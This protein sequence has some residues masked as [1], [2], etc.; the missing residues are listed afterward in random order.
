MVVPPEDECENDAVFKYVWILYTGAD[1]GG[2]GADTTEDYYS[3]G[4]NLQYLHRCFGTIQPE[5]PETGSVSLFSHSEVFSVIGARYQLLPYIYSEYMK[6]ALRNTMMFN[7]LS[8]IYGKDNLARQVEDQL[9]VGENIMIAPVCEQNVTGRVVYF[10]ER[11]KQ[12]IFKDGIIEEGNIF[13]KG[14]SYVNMPMGTVNVFLREG[15]LLPVA[16]GGK[17]VE[18]INFED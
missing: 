4:Q 2:F 14:F 5:E 8:F 15:Y 11:M 9:L 10:P 16:K 3:D 17:C 7:P 12:L 13:E 6:A 18:D 1:V